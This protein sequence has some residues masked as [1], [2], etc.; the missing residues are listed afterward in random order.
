MQESPDVRLLLP[1]E[2]GICGGHQPGTARQA[3]QAGGQQG[4]HPPRFRQQGL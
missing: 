4:K 3:D 1:M 2:Q